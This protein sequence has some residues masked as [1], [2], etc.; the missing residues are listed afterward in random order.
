VVT[1]TKITKEISGDGIA[2]KDRSHPNRRSLL[3]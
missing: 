2:Y 1:W 3:I